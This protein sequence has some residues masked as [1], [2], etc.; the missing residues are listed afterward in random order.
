MTIQIQRFEHS[1]A[2]FVSWLLVDIGSPEHVRG[3][4]E[5]TLNFPIG[6]GRYVWFNRLV[7]N[8]SKARGQRYGSLLLEAALPW[9]DERHLTIVNAENPYEPDKA[10]LVR[11]FFEAHGFVPASGDPL[12]PDGLL[13]R[14][15]RAAGEP[16]IDVT[17]PQPTGTQSDVGD[18]GVGG[19]LP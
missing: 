1:G 14:R 18:A 15:P 3:T 16:V 10:E 17:S 12:F 6:E 4:A 5:F 9:F 7:I 11:R 19:T 13:V 2:N 8:P